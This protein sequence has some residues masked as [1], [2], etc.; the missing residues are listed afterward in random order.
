M[1]F[2]SAM[3]MHMIMYLVPAVTEHAN[4]EVD[5]KNHCI[6]KQGI[7]SNLIKR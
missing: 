7:I 4:R 6:I 5:A 3:V 2:L 1:I